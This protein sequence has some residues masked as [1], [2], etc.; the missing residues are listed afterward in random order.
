M[1]NATKV[2]EHTPS[3]MDRAVE[4]KA[5]RAQLKMFETLYGDLQQ[6]LRE[7][8]TELEHLRRFLAND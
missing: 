3:P 8:Q 4:N 5:L 2:I 6:E 1:A 7:T